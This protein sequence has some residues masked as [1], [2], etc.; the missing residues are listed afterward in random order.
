MLE[1]QPLGRVVIHGF[2]PAKRAPVARML[3]DDGHL[4]QSSKRSFR[5]KQLEL[6]FRL[7][8]RPHGDS[9]CS[10]APTIVGAR[11]QYTPLSPEQRAAAAF[12]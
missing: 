1:Q 9:Q 10:C 3:H 8:T 5:R 11:Q 12:E 7:L 4:A 6:D 2:E